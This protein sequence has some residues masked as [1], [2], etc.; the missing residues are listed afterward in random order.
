MGALLMEARLI[1]LLREPSRRP[2]CWP[3]WRAIALV[4]ALTLAVVFA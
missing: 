2:S 3:V 4:V 1:V